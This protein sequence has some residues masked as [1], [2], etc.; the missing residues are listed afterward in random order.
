MTKPLTESA[1]KIMHHA[2]ETVWKRSLSAVGPEHLLLSL[3]PLPMHPVS[4]DRKARLNKQQRPDVATIH[5]HW[6]NFAELWE[7][8]TESERDQ[9]MLALLEQVDIHSNE[10][11]T[12][13]V[14]LSGQVPLS[15]VGL[16]ST[17]RA[18]VRLELT[19]FGL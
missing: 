3:L 14:R 1:K 13:K 18:G 7:F 6:K 19:T 11:G 15:N 10:K 5:G 17:D 2:K 16:T 4:A 9:V 8:L 12:C